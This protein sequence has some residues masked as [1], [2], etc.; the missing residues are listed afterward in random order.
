MEKLRSMENELYNRLAQKIISMIP[1][2]WEKVYYLGEVEKNQM[3]WSS[4]FYFEETDSHLFIKSHNIPEKYD[5]SQQK[6][7]DSLKMEINLMVFN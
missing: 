4:V 5:I 6:Y 2:D 7:D 1:V 3:S